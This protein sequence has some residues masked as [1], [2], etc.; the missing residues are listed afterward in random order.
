LGH[1]HPHCARR[2]H[3]VG[4]IADQHQPVRSRPPSALVARHTA[5]R[6]KS[7]MHSPQSPALGPATRGWNRERT[8]RPHFLTPWP[9][10]LARKL[11]CPHQTRLGELTPSKKTMTGRGAFEYNSSVWAAADPCQ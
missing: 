5:N 1:V 8:H 4:R 2:T 9:H 11:S 3:R 10:R 7:A 6:D